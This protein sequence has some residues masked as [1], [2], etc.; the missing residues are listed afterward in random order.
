MA[1][2]GLKTALWAPISA[3]PANAA[4]TYGEIISVGK[5]ISAKTTWNKSEASLYADD[6]L[7]ENENVTNSGTIELNVDDISSDAISGMLGMEEVTVSGS[8]AVKSYRLNSQ[9]APN[10]GFGYIRNGSRGGVPY[11]VGYVLYKVKFGAED[12]EATTKGESVEYQT[13]T[14]SGTVMGVNI[15]GKTVFMEKTAELSTNEA[16]E[17]WVRGKLGA[18]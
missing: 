14:V 11:Y 13:T 17:A 1:K 15:S 5:M 7:V 16:A 6:M 18:A 10:G 2:I 12:E 9:S 8:G 3:E 4:P